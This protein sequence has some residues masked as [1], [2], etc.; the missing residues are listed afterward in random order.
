M[1]FYFDHL[2][3]DRA[4]SR[5]VPKKFR[6]KELLKRLAKWQQGLDWN[7]LYLENHDQTRIVSHYGDD[8]GAGERGSPWE[9][10]AKLM[11]TLLFTLRGTPFIF[12]GQEIGMTNFDLSGLDEVKDIEAHNLDRLMKKLFLPKGLRWKWLRLSSRDNSRTPY[13]WDSSAQAGFSN[14]APWLKVNA[15]HKK[16]NYAAQKND[17]DSV[18]SYY[19]KMAALRA[20]SGT[21]QYGGFKPLLAK[22]SLLMYSREADAVQIA[23]GYVGR[24]NDARAFVAVFNFSPKRIKLNG[25]ARVLLQGKIAAS[26]IGRTFWDNSQAHLE[27]WEALVLQAN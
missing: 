18:L 21:L 2:E 4:F 8:R 6:A 14:G 1:V 10:S 7:A 23:Q 17:P 16:L 13:Q 15:N 11:A 22:G 12:Q 5:F 26:N 27:A 19:K 9:R 24:Q 20:S 25:D 3:V